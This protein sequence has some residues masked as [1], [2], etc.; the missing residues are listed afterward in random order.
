[1]TSTDAENEFIGFLTPENQ[2]FYDT[3]PY[4]HLNP[5]NN[6]FRILVGELYL[7]DGFMFGKA[8]NMMEARQ[9]E[10]QMFEIR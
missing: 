1:M 8:M 9:L 3:N 6:E 2:A 10:K 5:D 7:S 4:K